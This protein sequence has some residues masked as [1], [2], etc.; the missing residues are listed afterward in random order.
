MRESER[1]KRK[2]KGRKK[3][4]NIYEMNSSE[5]WM[6]SMNITPGNV[7]SFS[8]LEKKERK[9][10]E[11]E[12]E[13]EKCILFD[14]CVF[15]LIFLTL[16]TSK[17]ISAPSFIPSLFLSLSLFL[18]LPLFL[19]LSL[20]L[21]GTILCLS[22]KYGWEIERKKK[23]CSLCGEWMEKGCDNSGT[24]EERKRKIFV[25][26]MKKMEG[27]RRKEQILS[28]S[29]SLYSFPLSVSFSSFLTRK[30]GM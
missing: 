8:F 24:D 28:L 12:Q 22:S 21:Y 3:E 13:E 7:L 14:A 30:D 15:S 11:I 9:K 4:P 6:Y 19:S 23:M 2:R 1:E 18:F 17:N 10:G 27:M 29:S 16:R 25:L 5:V 20:S 26:G